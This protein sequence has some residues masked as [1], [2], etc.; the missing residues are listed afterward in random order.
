MTSAIGAGGWGLVAGSAFV[1]GGVCRLRWSLSAHLVGLLTGF[2]AGALIA[3][4]AYEL[5]DEAGRLSGGNGLVGLGLVTGSLVYLFATGYWASF[6]ETVDV[7]FRSLLVTVVPE[8]V[9][10]VG[11]LVSG[12]HIGVAMIGAIFFCGVPEAFVATGRLI[13][14]GL[15]PRQIVLRWMGLALLCGVSAAIAYALLQDAREQIVAVVL[16]LA[17]GAVL[18]ELTTELV[19]ESRKLSGPLGGTAAVVG[20][21]IVFALVELS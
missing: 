7:S 20:F 21:A 6:E 14:I 8:A 11:S 2:G 5:V 19:P 15:S 16:A 4:V 9:I 12:H 3:A 18:T 17:G 1:V 10:I 13:E